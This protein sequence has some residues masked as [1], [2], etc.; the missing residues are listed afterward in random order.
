MRG[1]VADGQGRVAFVRFQEMTVPF[2]RQQPAAL[3]QSHAIG[4]AHG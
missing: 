3:A 2:F 4:V 1:T